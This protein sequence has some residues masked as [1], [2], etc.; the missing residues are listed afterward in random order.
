MGTLEL[1]R[2][3]DKRSLLDERSSDTHHR[4]RIACDR[5]RENA[6][7]L[8]LFR[9]FLA[10]RVAQ[11]SVCDSPTESQTEVC[12]TRGNRQPHE[13]FS[14]EAFTKIY[15]RYRERVY[16]Y[17][18]RVL[19]NEQ[20]A[21]DLFQ[22]VFFRVYTRAE[23]FTEEKSLGGWIFTIAH[24]LCLNKVRDRKPQEDLSDLV[25]PVRDTPDS[26]EDWREVIARAMSLLPVEYREIIIL[27]EYEG[28]SYAE[29]REVLHTTIPSIKSRLYRAKGKLRELLAPYYK[30]N[31][32]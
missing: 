12:A 7:D 31:Y 14:R 10:G 9:E 11:T 1:D 29:I 8:A 13:Q 27:R 5:E 22:E 3:M 23:S 25:L 20:D 28:M 4:G 17:A 16:A 19:S 30:E 32:R 15:L 2:T 24:N 18:L 21:E 6:E 26:G